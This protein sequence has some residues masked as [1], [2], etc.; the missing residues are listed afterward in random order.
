MSGVAE[1]WSQRASP[2]RDLEAVGVEPVGDDQQPVG[3]PVQRPRLVVDERR[4][5][6]RPGAA[7]ALEAQLGAAQ[8]LGIGG[9]D[10]CPR[11]TSAPP[12]SDS[13]KTAG[14]EPLPPHRQRAR[15]PPG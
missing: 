2:D 11:S 12:A 4:E 8:R 14:P 7:R 5:A 9:G 1:R 6:R 13:A 15:R 10:A 3:V